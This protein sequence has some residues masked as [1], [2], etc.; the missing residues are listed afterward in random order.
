MAVRVATLGRETQEV[1][2]EEDM[3]PVS[4]YLHTADVPVNGETGLNL[5]GETADLETPVMEDTSV[6]VVAP[7]IA[8]G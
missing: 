5:N 8:N 7:K 3:R 1:P 2:F 4:Y 6:I